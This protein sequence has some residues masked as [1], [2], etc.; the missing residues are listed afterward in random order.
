MKVC[1]NPVSSKL[2]TV[3]KGFIILDATKN[4]LD[5][6]EEVKISVLTGVWKTLV[7]AL[8]DNFEKFK[9]SVKEVTTD[10]EMTK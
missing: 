7:P 5:S 9:T 3:W 4:I 10:V 2:K 1:G 6:R 8:M